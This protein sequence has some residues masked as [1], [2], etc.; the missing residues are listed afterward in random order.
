MWNM[1]IS[2]CVCAL[3]NHRQHISDNYTVAVNLCESFFLLKHM[4]RSLSHVS[5]AQVIAFNMCKKRFR[6][7]CCYALLGTVD[8]QDKDR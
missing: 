2:G 1:A 8:N 5:T 6:Y 4:L 7:E 3:S